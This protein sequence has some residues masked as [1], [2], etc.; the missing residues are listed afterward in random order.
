MFLIKIKI[1]LQKLFCY[2][3]QVYI[4]ATMSSSPVRNKNS[5]FTSADDLMIT[6]FSQI[7]YLLVNKLIL[8]IKFV[9]LL[10]LIILIY[11]I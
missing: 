1:K 10:S 11:S 9:F 2:K 8:A 4:L 6:I 3:K 5:Q 7:T